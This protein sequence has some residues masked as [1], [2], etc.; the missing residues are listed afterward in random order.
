VGLAAILL[1]SWVLLKDFF[2]GKIILGIFC[3]GI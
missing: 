3:A 2:F 1:I